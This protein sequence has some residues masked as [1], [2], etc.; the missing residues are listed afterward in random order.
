VRYSSTGAHLAGEDDHVATV[1]PAFERVGNF[2][3]FVGEAFD[4]ALTYAALRKA[5]TT[6]RP[7][8]SPQWLAD[9]EERTGLTLRPRKRGPKGIGKVQP[10]A[11]KAGVNRGQIRFAGV[12]RRPSAGDKLPPDWQ[13]RHLTPHPLAIA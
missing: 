11:A 8:G 6:G 7:V 2:A 5:E 4:E 9:L 1:A 13:H 3:A 10:V 12:Q